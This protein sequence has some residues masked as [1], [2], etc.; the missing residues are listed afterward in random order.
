MRLK[1]VIA[2]YSGE[3]YARIRRYLDDDVL[4]V[5]AKVAHMPREIGEMDQDVRVELVEMHVLADREGRVVLDTSVFVREDIER[6]LEAVTPLARELAERVLESG[7]AFKG[8]RPE[9]T[10]FLAGILGL[11]QGLGRATQ[12]KHVG[13]DWKS[14][15]GK[16]AQSKVDFD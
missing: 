8:A 5:I 2:S 14:Y 4:Q 10:L 15:S 6:I 3:T 7:S 1:P 13:V 11:V 16:Y 12:I 9:V